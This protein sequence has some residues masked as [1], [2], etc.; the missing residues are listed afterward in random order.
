MNFATPNIKNIIIK[1]ISY[2]FCFGF[3]VGC[4]PNKLS[5]KLNDKKYNS[6]PIPIISGTICSLGLMFSPLLIMNYFCNGMYFDKLFDKYTITI[7]RYHQ[8]DGK[9]NKY[10]FPSLIILSI[11]SK[12]NQQ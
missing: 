2:G 3:C 7:E 12:N 6:L 1:S 10:A 4:F 11:Q 5:V 9:S 8:Y